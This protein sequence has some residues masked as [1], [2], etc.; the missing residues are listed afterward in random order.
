MDDHQ[1]VKRNIKVLTNGL[2][3]S[4]PQSREG[5]HLVVYSTSGF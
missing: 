1:K 2:V 4:A 5:S 3:S